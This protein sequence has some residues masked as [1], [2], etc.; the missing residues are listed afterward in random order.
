MLRIWLFIHVPACCALL[1]ALVTH[2]ITVF[3]YW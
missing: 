1:A 2:V 3:L